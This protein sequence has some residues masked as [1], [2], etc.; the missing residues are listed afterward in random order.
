MFS[1]NTSI[2]QQDPGIQ[3]AP[4]FQ[5]SF[6]FSGI[7]ATSFPPH[8]PF[9]SNIYDTIG[10][11]QTVGSVE[12]RSPPDAGFRSTPSTPQGGNDNSSYFKT[13]SNQRQPLSSTAPI[14]INGALAS[15]PSINQGLPPSSRGPPPPFQSSV[16]YG[17]QGGV[18][19]NQVL[20]AVG[21]NMHQMSNNDG[22]FIFGGDSDNEDD[23]V[24]AFANSNLNMFDDAPMSAP[25]HH[26]SASWSGFN[27]HITNQNGGYDGFESRNSE[28][29]AGN[30]IDWVGHH[31]G[32][33]ASSVSEIRNRNQDP[34]QQKIARTISTPNA[35]GLHGRSLQASQ[36][37]STSPPQTGFD[38]AESSRP[39]SPGGSK[40][41]D[42]QPTTC[43]NCLTQTT[44]L[45]RRNPEGQPLCNACG[46]FLKL[47]GVVRPLSLKTDVI[48]KRNRGSGNT[49]GPG[50]SNN[51]S[52]A[53]SRKNS[54]VQA[55]QP[56]IQ[57]QPAKQYAAES[58]SPRSTVSAGSR[59]TPNSTSG[60][61]G[62][63]AIAP[64]PP[65]PGSTELGGAS[66]VPQRGKALASSLA[67]T[68]KRLKR[69]T[70]GD[71]GAGL[72]TIMANA[73]D[74]GGMSHP[75]HM[76]SGQNDGKMDGSSTDWEWLTMSL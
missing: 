43:T 62:N 10:F 56:Q 41:G 29:F 49:A 76:F 7:E 75:M 11:G 44:P 6:D 8:H 54:I 71:D 70:K 39:T 26:T 45:W 28:L 5:N 17:S 36:D 47:H 30:D 23:D 50:T 13:V 25:L 14:N 72:D 9:G 42:Q 55:P 15:N 40:P 73:G 64:G 53:K 46:L 57:A 52:R 59:G 27:N 65:K 20:H 32:A 19:P 4:P 21:N 38:T 16:H 67:T 1:I 60:G 3:S 51:R 22:M 31:D 63:V 74:T 18:N 12:H 69:P 2:E 24:T 48:K 34:R 68:P 61:K 35:A 66:S 33:A 58:E 37:N